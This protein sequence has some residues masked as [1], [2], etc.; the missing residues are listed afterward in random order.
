[1]TIQSSS[2]LQSRRSRRLSREEEHDLACRIRDEESLALELVSA[3]PAARAILEAP[4]KHSGSTRV[5]EV[6]RLEEAVTAAVESHADTHPA[7]TSAARAALSRAESLR[8]Q[9][10]MSG[11]HIARGEARKLSGMLMTEEDL[12]Q[13]GYIGLM[14]A[15]RRFEPRRG[16]R[17]STYAHWWVRAQITRTIDRSGRAVHVS[18]MAV[19]QARTLRKFRDDL[20]ATGESVSYEKL[21]EYTG[22]RVDRIHELLTPTHSISLETPI[23][24]TSSRTMGDTLIDTTTPNA[25]AVYGSEQVL[26][27]LRGAFQAVLS[28]REQRVLVRRYGLDEE[29]PGTLVAVGADMGLSR[30]RVRQLERR[31]IDRLSAAAISNSWR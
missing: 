11:H 28:A 17:F 13:E 31:A 16:L 2:P 25:D 10:A 23:E 8:W 22:I 21:S 29:E 15:A 18:A 9:L 3:L 19:D 4:V 26:G 6:E 7:D 14:K 27:Q 24:S 30:E 5:G 12:L 20:K 1:M